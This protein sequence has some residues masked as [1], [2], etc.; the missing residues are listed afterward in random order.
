VSGSRGFTLLEVLVAVAILSL[1]AVALIQLS[2]QGLRLLKQSD[3]H[4]AA[5]LLADRLAREATPLAEGVETGTA[6]ELA[7]ERRVTAVVTPDALHAV[8]GRVAR[9]F[10]LTVTVRWSR[11]ASLTLATL[12]TVPGT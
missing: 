4:Q 3:S 1:G 7:W 5:V 2:A 6:G 11:G 10:E 9:L 8:E 12:R